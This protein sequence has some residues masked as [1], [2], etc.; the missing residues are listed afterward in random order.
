MKETGKILT[1]R[2]NRLKDLLNRIPNAH[3]ISVTSCEACLKKDEKSSDPQILVQKTSKIKAIYN[4]FLKI[5]NLEKR[6]SKSM[7]YLL[8]QTFHGLPRVRSPKS[9]DY[10]AFKNQK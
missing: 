10:Y 2:K 1:K 3:F 9:R 6:F 5:A 7:E 8:I 4:Q